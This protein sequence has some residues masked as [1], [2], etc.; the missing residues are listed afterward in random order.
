M[1]RNMA[2]C[3]FMK[4]RQIIYQRAGNWKLFST[5]LGYARVKTFKSLYEL[6]SQGLLI[7]SAPFTCLEC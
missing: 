4:L 5:F 7:T 3:L 2:F 1:G 6:T